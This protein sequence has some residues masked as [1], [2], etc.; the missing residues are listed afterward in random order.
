MKAKRLCLFALSATLA[1]V[2]A[3]PTSASASGQST[4]KMMRPLS[5]PAPASGGLLTY[6]G[7]IA[8]I[9]VETVPTVYG[10]LWGWTSDP[11][12]EVNY[13]KNFFL[14][15]GGSPWAN[16]TTQY[17]QSV[18]IGT[19]DCSTVPGAVFATNPAHVVKSGWADNTNPLPARPSQTDIAAEADRAAVHFGNLTAASNKTAMYFILTPKGHS[20]PG[21]DLI[22]CAYHDYRTPSHGEV[23]FVN[24]PYI[25]DAGLGCGMNF[26]NAGPAGVLDGLSIVAGHE[27]AETVTDQFPAGGWVD[28]TVAENGD[29]CAWIKTGQ[30]AAQNITLSTGTFAV[31]SL[32]SNAFNNH[33]G[34]CVV[35]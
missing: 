31:Q 34:G 21:F 19:S 5:A 4:A 22:F 24:L 25:T 20:T 28:S 17:C 8:G 30:G 18:P 13:L 33:A 10:I 6:H 26:V 9:G 16:S 7:G 3:A 27:Y 35:S 1:M 29:K 11:S 2:A 32:W 15:V 14:G 12:G 23:A